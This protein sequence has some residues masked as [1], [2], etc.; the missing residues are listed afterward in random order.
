M[1]ENFSA[2][3]SFMNGIALN[4]NN[5]F[6]TRGDKAQKQNITHAFAPSSV[7]QCK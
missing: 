5:F 1:S 3:V 2:Q 7:H 6:R 4:H